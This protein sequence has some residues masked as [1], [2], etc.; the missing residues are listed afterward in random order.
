MKINFTWHVSIKVLFKVHLFKTFFKI[1]S[2]NYDEVQ[3]LFND[4]RIPYNISEFVAEKVVNDGNFDIEKLKKQIFDFE[5]FK[6][7][8]FNKVLSAKTIKLLSC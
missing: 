4:D 6:E 5:W 8:G 7:M 1:I 3:K 2:E